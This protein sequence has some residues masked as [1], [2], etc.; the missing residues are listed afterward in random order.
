MTKGIVRSRV[1]RST[2]PVHQLLFEEHKVALMGVAAQPPVL[3]QGIGRQQGDGRK[4]FSTT[5]RRAPD[6]HEATPVPR[7]SST[8]PRA[9]SPSGQLYDL[10]R[11]AANNPSA[12][13]AAAP[14][15]TVG[16]ISSQL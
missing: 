9:G 6:Q 12:V 16:C 8:D 10:R 4:G 11:K 3:A 13:P 7:D 2:A 14:R 1:A 15:L 5:Q